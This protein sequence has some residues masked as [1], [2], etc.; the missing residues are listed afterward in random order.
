MD[1]KQR[2]QIGAALLRIANE[3]AL[4]SDAL[5][6][7]T[8]EDLATSMGMGNTSF[9]FIVEAD[10]VE[11]LDEEERRRW[12]VIE[13]N[14]DPAYPTYESQSPKVIPPTPDQKNYIRDL[15]ARHPAPRVEH[16]MPTTISE[17]RDLIG[18]L[19]EMEPATP[20][21]KKYI[22]DLWRRHGTPLQ[23]RQMPTTPNEATDL[24]RS[25]KEPS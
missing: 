22:R 17:A 15:W 8:Q 24:I 13:A 25:Y 1:A 3:M 20:A 5:T 14:A 9:P 21:Q 10:P 7:P 18:D 6:T 23:D 12:A 2:A 16:V 19:V 11:A 4:I